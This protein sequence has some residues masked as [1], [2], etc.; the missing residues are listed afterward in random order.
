M[1]PIC[2]EQCGRLLGDFSIDYIKD[3]DVI[4]QKIE[5]IDEDLLDEEEFIKINKKY[6]DEI[7]NLLNK[8]HVYK[9]CCRTVLMTYYPAIKY[10][11]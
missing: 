11:K 7:K 6:E 2:C 3:V 10:I 4:K 5:E 1:I 9:I 8:Y